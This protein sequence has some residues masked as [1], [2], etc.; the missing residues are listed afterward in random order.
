[1]ADSHSRIASARPGAWRRWLRDR[2][3]AHRWLVAVLL[4][5]AVP[6]LYRLGDPSLYVDEIYAVA[7][8]ASAPVSALVLASG[9]PHPPLYYLLLR[10][11]LF[12]FGDTALAARSLSVAFGLACLPAVYALGRALFD[13]TRG[14]LA[15][16]LVAL[17]PLHVHLSRIARMYTLYTLLAVLSLYALLWFLRRGTR[18]GLAA[19]VAATALLLWTH[20]FGVFVL[21]AEWLYV[22]FVHGTSPRDVPLSLRRWVAVQAAVLALALPALGPL[23]ARVLAGGEPVANVAW[24]PRPT[25]GV[26]VDTALAYAGFPD[27]YPFLAGTPTLELLAGVVAAAGAVACLGYVYALERRDESLAVG[28]SPVTGVALAGLV[29]AA[30][31]LGPYV[32]SHL[33]VPV[34]VVKYTAPGSVAAALL[35]AGGVTKVA[36]GHRRAFLLAVLV[37]GLAL[38][39]AAYLATPTEEDWAG[40]AAAVDAEATPDDLLV[41]AP[42]WVE[43]A[44]AH[45]LEST[46]TTLTLEAAGDGGGTAVDDV[47]ERASERRVVW[48]VTFEGADPGDVSDR[49][50]ATHDLA[51][52]ERFGRVAVS[53]YVRS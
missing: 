34:Y 8:R 49:L 20:V 10:G 9:D 14:L 12:A 24:I 43:P 19:Y 51:S 29:L 38:P 37:T 1:M 5:G 30:T 15:A 33:F 42:G 17:S 11:W 16:L 39:T 2:L 41:V 48:L 26:F 23:A 22:A 31:T 32:L 45:Y 47:A 46:P 44:L 53:R 25:P 35:V 6:R 36:P 13:D 3:G 18:R 28:L 27:Q 4:V 7:V 21:L 50:A 52:R 40:A